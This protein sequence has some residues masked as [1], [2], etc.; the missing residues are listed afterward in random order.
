M[1]TKFAS[2]LTTQYLGVPAPYGLETNG[3]VATEFVDEETNAAGAIVIFHL[4]GC[5]VLAL[6]PRSELAR[7]VHARR[8]GLLS[9]GRREERGEDFRRVARER[10]NAPDG[11]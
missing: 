4:R 7:A 8:T 6:Y 3:V 10:L 9:G 1:G 11:Y 5:L 2:V